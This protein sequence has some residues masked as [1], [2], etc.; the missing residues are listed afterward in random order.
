MTSKDYYETLGINRS[1]SKEDVKKAFRKLAAKFHPDRPGG[2]EARFKEVSE[3]Y[4][5]L[6]D[7]KKRAEY[8]SYG[9]VFDEGGAGGFSDFAGGF[10]GFQDVGFEDIL[11][12][13]FG[14]GRARTR[15]GRDISLVLEIT[16]EESIFGTERSVL[17]TKSSVCAHCHGTGG[18]EKIGVETCTTCNGKGR[19]RETRNSIIG[20]FTS[21]VE[22]SACA[23]TGKKYKEKCPACRGAGIQTKQE[24]V[25]IKIP[26]G[27]RDGEVIRMSGMGEA[28]PRSIPGDL[29]I[30][31]HIKAHPHFRREGN[32][33]VMDLNIK[34]SDA[35]LGSDYKIETLEG[36]LTLNV[37]AGVSI[38]ETL[39]VRGKG[40]PV[41]TSRR[42]DLLVKLHITLPQRL[43]KSAKEII[44]KLK[45]EGI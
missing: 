41:S 14:G 38:G 22:C 19:I 6:S 3:A 40:V 10:E 8:D 39:R 24:D 32:D 34:L 15:R 18:E 29:Y 30:K 20:S 28:A 1:A 42:G 25:S 45:K 31:V 2:D 21:V 27:M 36:P 43:S 35:L 16:F 11:S 4:H 9:R 23:G 33:L 37:P 17:L 13:F 44:E 5:V 7:D 26:P 12:E